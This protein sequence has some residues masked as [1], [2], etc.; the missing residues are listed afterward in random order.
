MRWFEN[1]KKNPAARLFFGKSFKVASLVTAVVTGTLVAGFS[2][3]W[4]TRPFVSTSYYHANIQFRAGNEESYDEIFNQSLVHILEMYDRH[5]SWRWTLECQGLLVEMAHENYTH[6]YDLIREQNLRG[7]LELVVPQYSHALAVAYGYKDFADSINYSR[8][9]LEEQ[10]GLTISDVIVL[11]EGQWLP[12]FG[13]VAHLGFDTFVVSRD[14]L[15]YHN[16]FPHQPILEWDY[17]GVKAHVMPVPWLPIFEAGVYHHQLALSDSERINTGDIDGPYEWNYN[18]DKMRQVE[19]RHEELERLGNKFLTLSEWKDYCI[20]HGYLEKMG[21][22]MP[23]SHWTPNRHQSVSRWMAW[24]TGET[25]DGQ[26]H[27]R[28]FYTRNLL[29]AAEVLLEDSKAAIPAAKYG[30]FRLN[31]T[32]AAKHLWM[33]QVTD[34]S[35]VNPNK[36]ELQY[37]VNNTALAQSIAREVISAIRVLR[38]LPD[39][40]QVNCRDRVVYLDTSLFTNRSVLAKKTAADLESKYGF[41]LAVTYSERE[42]LEADLSV[43]SERLETVVDGQRRVF[44]FDVLRANFTGPTGHLITNDASSLNASALDYSALFG[45]RRTRQSFTFAGNWINATYSP[46]LLENGTQEVRRSDYRNP[47]IGRDP[48]YIC[49]LPIANG[50][51]YNPRDGY[52]IITNNTVRHVSVK[53]ED[54]SVEYYETDQKFNSE[55]EFIITAAPLADA[56]LLADLVNM[57]PTLEV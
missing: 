43:T 44:T 33:A 57:Y 37:A 54:D 23:E 55:Y 13:Q 12:A 5:P 1:R 21:R 20:E 49:P 24:G 31:L 52:A 39:P 38:G 35:G 42:I 8:W 17:G 9:L 46:S 48:D 11:Q 15:S 10:Y 34:T 18:P 41:A 27:A 36:V 50:L 30:E 26:V 28:N 53:W 40:I 56:L 51:L 14:Q 4:F 47:V 6:V 2:I 45:G 22:F 25:D 19:A 29:L 16:Y 7:Q 3:Y 32:T